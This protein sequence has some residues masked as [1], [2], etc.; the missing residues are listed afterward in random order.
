MTNQSKPT[1]PHC[2]VTM[3]KWKNPDGSSWNG[4]FQYA[5]F[6]D[7]C[8]YYQRG[9]DWMKQNYNVNASYRYRLDPTTGDTGPLPVWSRTAVRNFIIEDEET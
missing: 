5:C 8:P 2:G 4:L 6:N 1:C 9:W 7:D 3:L